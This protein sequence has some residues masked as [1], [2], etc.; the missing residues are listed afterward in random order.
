MPNNSLP[1]VHISPRRARPRRS[2]RA[3]RS[4][5]PSTLAALV[6]LLA[7]SLGPRAAAHPDRIEDRLLLH[8]ATGTRPI[9]NGR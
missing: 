8:F 6:T 4:T 5:A 2:L 7:V 9:E 3:A 1:S